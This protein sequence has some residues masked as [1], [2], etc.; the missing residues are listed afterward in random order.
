MVLRQLYIHMQKNEAGPPTSILKKYKIVIKR[1]IP[2]AR[3]MKL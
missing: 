2:E 3:T 1:P